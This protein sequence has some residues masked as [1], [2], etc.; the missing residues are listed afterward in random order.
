MQMVQLTVIGRVANEPTFRN[1][2]NSQVTNFR[3]LT[4][5]ST[6]GTKETISFE[7]AAWNQLAEVAVKNLS[8]GRLVCVTSSDFSQKT[9]NANNKSGINNYINVNNIIMLDSKPK[10]PSQTIQNYDIINN[11]E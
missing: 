10:E 4:N 3:I 2:K 8:I 9:W 7:C 1:N 5:R 6:N 11:E